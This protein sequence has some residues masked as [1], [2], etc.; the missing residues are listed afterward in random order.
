MGLR[1]LPAA[2][3]LASTGL[4]LIAGCSDGGNADDSGGGGGSQS[5]SSSRP[6]SGKSDSVLHQALS[7]FSSKAAGDSLQVEFGDTSHIASIAAKEGATWNGLAAVGASTILEGYDYADQLAIKLDAADYAISVGQ[8]PGVVT[9]IAGGQDADAVTT[10]AKSLGYGGAEVLSQDMNVSKVI[11]VGINQIKAAGS[12][13]VLGGSGAD[14]G[15]VDSKGTTLADDA[16]I[17]SLS[18]CLGDPAAA[19]LADNNGHRV[20]LGV[21]EDHGATVSTMCITADSGSAAKSLA[22]EVKQDLASGA[23][24]GGKKYA[25]MFG[26]SKVAVVSDDVVQAI[27]PNADGMNANTLFTMLAQG[28]LPGL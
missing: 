14:L 19:Y 15:Y 22:D 27:M 4:L 8:A 11:T 28:D 2:I 17:A 12:D 18:D 3:A 6:S 16:D 5:A 26:D 20:G 13:V 1:R 21:T 25:D 9:L 10:A 24:E 23:V 7:R